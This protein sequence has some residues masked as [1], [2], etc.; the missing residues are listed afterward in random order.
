MLRK[1]APMGV[2]RAV[3]RV[4]QNGANSATVQLV[5][6][7][8]HAFGPLERKRSRAINKTKRLLKSWKLPEA[9]QAIDE[10]ISQNPDLPSRAAFLLKAEILTDLGRHDEA[11]EVLLGVLAEDPLNVRLIAKLGGIGYRVDASPHIVADIFR[12]KPVD[13]SQ[14]VDAVRYLNE[15]SLFEE[16]K[17]FAQEALSVLGEDAPR[18]IIDDLLLQLAF[19]HER[20]GGFEHAIDVLKSIK[21]AEARKV[22][23]LQIAR[24][25]MERGNAAVG[26]ACLGYPIF[27]KDTQVPYDKTLLPILYSL[28]EIEL[29]HLSYRKRASSLA[30]AST[31]GMESPD[32]ILVASGNFKDQTALI[33]AEGGPGDEIRIAAIYRQVATYFKQVRITCDPRLEPLLSRSFPE[34][35]FIPVARYRQEFRAKSVEDRLNLPGRSLRSFMNDQALRAGRESA[36]VCSTL[37]LLAEFRP[38]REDFRNNPARLI[39]RAPDP[40][41]I[42]PNSE[43]LRVGLAWRSLLRS[44]TRDVH[45]LDVQELAP[46]ADLDNVEFW[47]LQAA[48]SEDEWAELQAILPDAVFLPKLDIKDDLDGLASVMSQLDLVVSPCTSILEMAG[49]LDVPTILMST[50]HSTTWRRNRDGTDVWFE[51]GVVMFAN[52]VWDRAALMRDVTAEIGR[53][54]ISKISATEERM[55]GVCLR[56]VSG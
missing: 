6:D 32:G 52:P 28:G 18:E 4:R 7:V 38:R 31:F 27:W 43:K 50:S 56:S 33:V 2:R 8:L 47:L 29:A 11:K 23:K 3:R 22:A 35:E 49:M 34:I 17:S 25:E 16:A 9:L 30:I 37:D 48:I 15:F 24:C 20:T 55:E 21:R 10:F 51:R 14:Y 1:I 26:A 53:R 44:S 13:A 19:A 12:S 45:Y 36:F 39:P 54:A 40:K 42:S 46:L 5:I 41:T